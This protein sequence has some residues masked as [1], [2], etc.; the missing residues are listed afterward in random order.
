MLVKSCKVQ[1]DAAHAIGRKKGIVE[2][3]VQPGSDSEGTV[4]SKAQSFSGC[5]GTA[6][7]A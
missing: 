6:E 5:E 3:K 7:E 1:S 2:S 4:E